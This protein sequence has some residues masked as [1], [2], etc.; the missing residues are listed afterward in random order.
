[1]IRIRWLIPVLAVV[2]A[3]SG[4]T[5]CVKNEEQPTG[6]RPVVVEVFTTADCPNCPPAKEALE[7]LASDYGT[8]KVLL[9]EYNLTGHLACEEAKTRAEEYGVSSIP[10]VFFNGQNRTEGKKSYEKYREIIDS[11]MSGD[12]SVA[13]SASSSFSGDVVNTSARVTNNGTDIVENARVFFV[14]YENTAEPGGQ[15]LVRDIVISPLDKLSAGESRDFNVASD[16]LFWCDMANIEV[17]A[18]VQASS[19][20][21]LHVALSRQARTGNK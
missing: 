3:I 8:D 16:A 13:I 6:V 1:M 18:F 2:L 12:T 10:V 7:D 17:V 19:G 9:L 15:Y 11:E 20:E 5:G 4:L 14:V 21:V